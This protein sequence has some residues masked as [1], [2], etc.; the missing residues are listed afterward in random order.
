MLPWLRLAAQ[1]QGIF[2]AAIVCLACT[3]QAEETP[4]YLPPGVVDAGWPSV[5]G[6][7]HDA[8]SPEVNLAESWPEEGPPVL[9]TRELGQGYSAF[10]AAGD[11]VYTQAQN[12]QGQSVYCLEARTGKT[13]WSHW[14]DW[15]YELAG[16][17]PGPRATPA[18]SRGR[19]VFAGPSGLIGC[20]DARTGRELWSRNVVVEFQG[21]GGTGFGYACSPTIVEDLVLLP[22]GGPQA[23]LV[24]LSLI[25]GKTVWSAGNR[26]ASYSPVLPIVRQGQLLV[27]G[28]LE[29]A[30][31]LHDMR[32]GELLHELELS[33]GYDE[34]SAWPIYRE[35]YLWLSA[36]F[37]SGSQLL[38]IPAEGNPQAALRSVW[39][40]RALSNDV[41]SSVLVQDQLY[42]FDLFDPQAKTQ[43]PSRGKFRCLDFLTGQERWEQGS[44][45]PH[46][47]NNETSGEI[48]QAGIVVA[49]GKL[50]LLN[51]QGD[52]ILLRVNPEHCEI[53]ARSAVLTG[54]LTW[55]PPILHRGCVY[56]RNHSRALSVF[57]GKPEFLSADQSTL[58]L[59]EIPQPRYFDWA[60]RVLSVEP[61]YAFDLPSRAWFCNWLLWSSGLL[62]A[63]LLLALIPA[64]SVRSVSR[65]SIWIVGYRSL[66]FVAGALGTTWL[67]H[68]TGDFV[69]TW[70][71]CLYVAFEPILARVQLRSGGKRA[72]W[73]DRIPVLCYLG[74]SVFYFLLCRR[75]GLLFEWAFLAGPLGA[76]PFGLWESR[77]MK[78]TF[79]GIL[80]SIVLKLLAYTCFFA[81][82][83]LVLWL[84]Y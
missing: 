16:V 73:L 17:Y 83:V 54:E 20:L 53:L 44:G 84:R 23:S 36:P 48:G 52:L 40:S 26:P 58:K 71:V 57:V 56:L 77:V 5:R 45:R 64:F 74:L 38:E 8:H 15:P 3:V 14:Y 6:V 70:P 12:L 59:S 4:W 41:L 2:A 82:G 76:L 42:G 13:V 78:E 25:D 28:Y 81:S 10:V 37:Q 30:L 35:P 65:K 24:A 66:A 46:R 60:G 32:T 79:S 31:V 63:S 75:L 19:L 22:V 61:E 80:C 72:G 18:L 55:T 51:E 50:I 49:D 11:R 9:W 47:S 43:R 1:C 33:Q 29:N 67:S 69:F 68:W 62:L 34:H 39:R 21:E 27:V 7:H